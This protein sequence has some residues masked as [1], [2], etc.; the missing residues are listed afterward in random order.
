MKNLTL[1]A[2]FLIAFA[3]C[4]TV[5]KVTNNYGN[6]RAS[7]LSEEEHNWYVQNHG[8]IWQTEAN[9]FLYETDANLRSGRINALKPIVAKRRSDSERE[10]AKVE[11]ENTLAEQQRQTE[12]RKAE[13]LNSDCTNG[14][15]KACKR[16][17]LDAYKSDNMQDALRYADLGCA[18]G[19]V[20]LCALAKSIL[21]RQSQTN[22]QQIEEQRREDAKAQ[23]KRENLRQFFDGMQKVSDENYER[24]KS[25][26]DSFRQPANSESPFCVVTGR[27]KDC[28]YSDLS[29]CRRQASALG[30]MCVAR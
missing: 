25:I 26:N 21:E 8:F 9:A 6:G 12:E 19:D 27:G 10:D 20:N 15:A 2:A 28:S 16:I 17:A 5:R 14:S 30:G 23:A 22:A 3:G 18:H 1:I 4:S 13:K 11:R 7:L 29:F 24:M